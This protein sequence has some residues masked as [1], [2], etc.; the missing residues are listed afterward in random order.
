MANTA[1]EYT[2][3]KETVE[4]LQSTIQKVFKALREAEIEE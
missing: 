1:E 3:V 2:A 4:L